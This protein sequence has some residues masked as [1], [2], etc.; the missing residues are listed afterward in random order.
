MTIEPT[1]TPTAT[2]GTVL[3]V[4]RRFITVLGADA[5][6]V[7]GTGS[8]KTLEV[9]AGDVVSYERRNGEVFVTAVE[10]SSRNLFRSTNGK[11][12]KMGANID[13]LLVITASGSTFN[14]VVIDRMLVAAQVQSIPATLVVNK[15]DLGTEHLDEMVAVYQRIGVPVIFSSAK[16]G[17]GIDRIISI[18][19]EPTARVLALC[20]VSGVGKSSILNKL[21]PGTRTKTGEVS[22]KTGQGKQTTTQPRGFLYGEPSS[23]QKIIIDLPGVQFF[24]LSH[25]SLEDVGLAFQEIREAASGC[26][27]D[28][29]KHL[30]EPECGVKG[31]VDRGEITPWRYESYL[32][33]VEEIRDAL[34]TWRQ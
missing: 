31:A 9:V 16:R 34:P 24:G 27:Y 29:C 22:D 19:R 2:T 25:I 28:D 21:I 11:L 14:P 17:D 12:K 32:Q 30:K 23:G 6:V 33:I 15:I 26:R 3:E 20:G 18:V 10:P 13:A 8:S 5:Q 7:T 4:S 1:S